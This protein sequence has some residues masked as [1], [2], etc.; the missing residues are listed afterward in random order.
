MELSVPSMILSVKVQLQTGVDCRI[1]K[2]VV[3]H[4]SFKEMHEL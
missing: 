4:S 2:T 1:L 3:I